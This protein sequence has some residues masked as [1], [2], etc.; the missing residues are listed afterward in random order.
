MMYLKVDG[1]KL[2][3]ES[4]IGYFTVKDGKLVA[5][6][7][8]D[9]WLH[10]LRMSHIEYNEQGDTALCMLDD[11]EIPDDETLVFDEDTIANLGVRTYF[12]RNNAIDCLFVKVFGMYVQCNDIIIVD[13]DN[14][15]EDV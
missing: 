12:E 7:F 4:N 11:D 10:K 3:K 14:V 9:L 2:P 13:G 15:E 5:Y 1:G 6:G 8:D